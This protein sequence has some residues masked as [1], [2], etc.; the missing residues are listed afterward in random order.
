MV[1]GGVVWEGTQGGNLDRGL[2]MNGRFSACLGV[3]ARTASFAR[4]RS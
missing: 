3:T 1:S 4:V 2:A